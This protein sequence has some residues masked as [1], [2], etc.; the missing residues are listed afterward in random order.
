MIFHVKGIW[1]IYKMKR[2]AIYPGSFDPFHNGHADVVRRAALIFD[3]VIILVAINSNKNHMFTVDERVEQIKNC[4]YSYPDRQQIV[5]VTS[6]DDLIPV[7]AN[8]LG[9]KYIIRGA[10]NSIDFEHELQ[11][12]KAYRSQD[13][14]LET[15][16][17]MPKSYGTDYISSSLVKEIARYGGH[18][19][20]WIEPHIA[21]AIEEKLK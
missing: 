10:R 1:L 21:K 8:D 18:Y 3:K 12:D 5:Q 16:I 17:M 14:I 9:A 11:L 20:Q 6:F 4:F 19:K 2:I 15:I 13:N 7:I